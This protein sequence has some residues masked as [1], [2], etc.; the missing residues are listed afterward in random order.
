MESEPQCIQNQQTSST[1]PRHT[2]P[3]LVQIPESVWFSDTFSD[4]LQPL[5]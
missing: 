5:V 1:H 3:H 2:G 4:A